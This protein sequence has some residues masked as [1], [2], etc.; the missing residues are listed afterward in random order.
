MT[1]GVIRTRKR[2]FYRP[3]SL[4]DLR[5]FPKRQLA[6][7]VDLIQVGHWF[8]CATHGQATDP[9]PAEIGERNRKRNFVVVSY[10]LRLLRFSCAPELYSET[11]AHV[12]DRCRLW[13]A[14]G[15]IVAIVISLAPFRTERISSLK[16]SSILYLRCVS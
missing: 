12:A 16:T 4:Q 7:A 6:H 9:L 2:F 13:I 8:C 1:S 15:R 5:K 14:V 11:V 10:V 3:A